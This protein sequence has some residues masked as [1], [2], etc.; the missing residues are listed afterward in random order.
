LRMMS[1]SIAKPLVVI[2]TGL[3]CSGKTTLARRL[4]ADLSLPL[5]TKDSLKELFFDALGWSDRAWSKKLGAASYEALYYFAETLL[6]ARCSFVIES[7]FDPALH[8]PRFAA[9]KQ[10]YD[11]A[12]VQIQCV[13]AGE[14]LIARFKTRTG[15]RHPGHVDHLSLDELRPSLLRGRLGF[16]NIGGAQVEVDTTNFAAVDYAEVCHLI[17]EYLN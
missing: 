14:V 13:A 17:R 4:A 7:N 15:H 2:V 6:A 5:V 12:L 16:L 11:F 10:Q 3:P 9:F 8:T 1:N